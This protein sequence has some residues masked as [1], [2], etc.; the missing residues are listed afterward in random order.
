MKKSKKKKT[1]K[2]LSFVII[3]VIIG[4]IGMFVYISVRNN[5][6]NNFNDDE[7]KYMY[8]YIENEFGNGEK[9]HVVSSDTELI[10]ESTGP[11]SNYDGTVSNDYIT[12]GIRAKIIGYFDSQEK[13]YA[14]SFSKFLEDN[15]LYKDGKAGTIVFTS[16]VNNDSKDK[17]LKNI[18]K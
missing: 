15:K 3:L 6:L 16:V 9:F 18:D 10:K 17:Y 7:W 5:K 8:N 11:T 13:M 12:L 2:I 4:I 14:V 1:S